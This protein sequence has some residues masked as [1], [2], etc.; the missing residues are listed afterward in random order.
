MGMRALVVDDHQLVGAALCDALAGRGDVEVV[1][2]ATTLDDALSL[3]A[4]RRPDVALV[5]LCVGP[6]RALDRMAE[7]R[8]A[9]PA[10]KLLV[11]T[12]W[13]SEHGL[14][15]ALAAGASG[16]LSKGQ[17]LEQLLDGVRRVH[18]GELVVC[19]DLLA[20]LVDRVTSGPDPAALEPREFDVLELLA[21]GCST[22]GIA[23]TLHVSEHTVR[24]RIQTLMAKLEVHT[25][26]EAVAEGLRLGLVLPVERVG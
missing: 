7:M 20:A 13:A 26:V 22:H 23:E 6:E 12:G 2:L 3:L 1:G 25:R 8:A 10:T 15:Q 19:P 9:S 17:P 24:N 16:F 14:D 21:E 18:A 11:V 5:D 4:S